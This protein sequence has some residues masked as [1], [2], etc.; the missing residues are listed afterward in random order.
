MQL[1]LQIC[2]RVS[3]CL[4]LSIN[5]LFVI[6]IVIYIYYIILLY[7]YIVAIA[8]PRL[9]GAGIGNIYYDDVNCAGTEVNITQCSH[10]GLGVHNCG[11]TEDAGVLCK[12]EPLVAV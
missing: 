9:Y 3:A 7:I 8:V 11:H 2:M 4:L 1:Q 5:L 6:L 10:R 12:R